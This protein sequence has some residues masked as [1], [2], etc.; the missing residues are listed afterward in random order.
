MET[1]RSQALSD[2]QITLLRRIMDRVP[3]NGNVDGA[4]GV[5]GERFGVSQMTIT[6]ALNRKPLKRRTYEKI[7]NGLPVLADELGLT[8]R[9]IDEMSVEEALDVIY[10][11]PPATVIHLAKMFK[12]L[13]INQI[14]IGR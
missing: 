8:K 7:A 11:L 4:R 6:N 2:S 14:G 13:G 9:A 10:H 1:N 3:I 12:G 5:L